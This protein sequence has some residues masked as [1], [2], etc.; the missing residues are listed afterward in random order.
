MKVS[1]K[2]WTENFFLSTVE[3]VGWFADV[4]RLIRGGYYGLLHIQNIIN[5]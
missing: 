2:R 4:N 3:L 5:F 1:N